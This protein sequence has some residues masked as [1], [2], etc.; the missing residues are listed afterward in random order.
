MTYQE[1]LDFLY[2]QLPMYQRVGAAAFK[3]DLNNTRD[4]CTY[5]GEPQTKF[6]SIHVA[7]TNGKGSSSHMLAAVFQAAGYKTGLYTSPHLK[8]FSERIR[9]NGQPIPQ[10]NVLAFVQQH[11]AFLENLKPSF[12]EMTVGMAFDYFAQEEVDIAIIEV[13]LGGRLDSTNVIYPLVSLITNIGLDHTD[14]LGNT[15]AEIAGEK[16]GIIK[17]EVPVVIGSY[18]AETRPVFQQKAQEMKSPITWASEEYQVTGIAQTSGYQRFSVVRQG[19]SFLENLDVSLLG[20]YQI[21]NL[22]GVLAT[23]NCLPDSQFLITDQAI[24]S[25]LGAVQQLT[26]LKGRWQV[27]RENPQV[28]ADTGHNKEAFVEIVRQLSGYTYRTLHMVIGLVQG[29]AVDQIF[30]LFPQ[31]AHYYFCQP[32]IP[33]ALPIED[34]ERQAKSFGF[35]YQIIRDVNQAYR[36]A[37]QNAQPDDFIY[38]GGST[39]VVAELEDL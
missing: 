14:M 6:K 23:I 33:R 26:G 21:Q 19:V 34:L 20:S 13:G 38:V 27:L 16:A 17:P 25:G 15:L 18:T 12:F 24:R 31:D 4:L 11:R 8:D 10:Q 30:S 36:A 7:G 1:A 39:F 2:Q 29:K 22:P 9:I 35:S 37:L 32:D 5:L 3:K 28:V